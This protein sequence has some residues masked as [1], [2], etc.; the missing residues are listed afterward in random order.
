MQN[1]TLSKSEKNGMK[2]LWEMP[3]GGSR[4]DVLEKYE[5]PKPA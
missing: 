1:Q 5:E 3:D 4:E 2:N